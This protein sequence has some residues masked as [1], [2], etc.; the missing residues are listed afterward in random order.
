M[1]VSPPLSST[2]TGTMAEIQALCKI[3]SGFAGEWVGDNIF[4][5]IL[6]LEVDWSGAVYIFVDCLGK[7]SIR[8][9][10]SPLLLV[11]SLY[12]F[13]HSFSCFLFI[14]CVSLLTHTQNL[15]AYQLG[16]RRFKRFKKAEEGLRRLKKAQEGSR[17][18][19][20]VPEG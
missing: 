13:S 7:N 20:K 2:L 10:S 9:E 4:L 11:S 14:Y 18:F 19:K 3:L 15:Q 1:L 17:R 6:I 16:S 5:A 8:L 12:L